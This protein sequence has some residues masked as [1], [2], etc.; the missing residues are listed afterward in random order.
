LI[1]STYYSGPEVA[2]RGIHEKNI[3]RGVRI[4]AAEGAPG[5]YGTIAYCL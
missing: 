4:A 5:G 2:V 3:M 1:R